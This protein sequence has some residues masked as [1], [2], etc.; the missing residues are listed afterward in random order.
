MSGGRFITK[1]ELEY[2]KRFDNGGYVIQMFTY[3]EGYKK[4]LKRALREDR[5]LTREDF[6][7]LY[8]EESLSYLE[9]MA[10]FKHDSQKK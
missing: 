9:E 7:A 8:G 5:P 3:E 1:E 4:L 6:L 10:T 2:Q